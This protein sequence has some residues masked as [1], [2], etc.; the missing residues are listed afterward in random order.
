MKSKTGGRRLNI[1]LGPSSASALDRLQESTESRSQV[2]VI[3][4]ALQTFSK[5]VDEVSAGGR[6][7]IQRPDGVSVE[8]F[9][10][11]ISSPQT[12]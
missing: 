12:R 5:M 4:L 11:V 1:E 6:V 8:I 10:P 3:R 2:E 9:F 7:V